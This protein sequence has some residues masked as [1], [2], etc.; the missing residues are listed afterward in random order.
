MENRKTEQMFKGLW[1]A[2]FTPV[3]AEGELNIQ[4]LEKLIE[5]LI[6]QQVDGLYILGS[7]G[8]GFLFSEEERKQIAA[9]SL[10]MIN[11]RVPVMVQVGSLTTEESIR[12][13]KH[14]AQ[15]GADGI[16]SVGPI[17]YAASAAMGIEHYRQIANATEL[18]F[19]PYQIG[20]A[21][22]NDE[23]I[24]KLMEIPNI[25][26]LKL[27]TGNMLEISNVHMKGAT[28]W[29]L[30]SGADELM[31]HAALCGTAGAIGTSYNLIGGTCKY[32]REEFLN[33]NVKL[34]IEFMLNL[35]ELILEIL[36]QIWTF[37]HRAM[38]LKHGIDIGKV[39]APLLAP[40][41]PWSDAE[42]LAVVEKLEAFAPQTSLLVKN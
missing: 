19:F 5:L 30:F 38:L 28:D 20:N 16:S 21:V 2:M 35:Q 40:E 10:E 26:G 22:M 37:F 29:K 13:A 33:G 1:P 3:N 31:C 25:A 11:K 34:G 42:V 18:P 12:L 15:H 23:V 6:D 36:P 27:T 14:A 24:K 39:K 41:L 17:Y 8:Q 9:I 4:E 7:T 32:V